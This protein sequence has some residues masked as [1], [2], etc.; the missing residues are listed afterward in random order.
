[1]D[2]GDEINALSDLEKAG[3]S[4]KN[5]HD[6]ELLWNMEMVTVS[7]ANKAHELTD[8]HIDRA[9]SI[10]DENFGGGLIDPSSRVLVNLW[11]TFMTVTCLRSIVQS[12]HSNQ[13]IT[14][15]LSQHSPN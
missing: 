9:K 3:Q 12:V 7:R 13:R 14:P 2:L 10:A 11:E 1:M 4:I 8:L 6:E 5:G 15:V